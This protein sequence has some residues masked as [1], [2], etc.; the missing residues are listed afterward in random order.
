MKA[1]TAARLVNLAVALVVLIVTVV[2]ICQSIVEKDLRMPEIGTQACYDLEYMDEDT[3][4]NNIVNAI[5]DLSG[6]SVSFGDSTLAVDRDN[7]REVASAIYSSG[8]KTAT[9]IGP[10]GGTL[11]QQSIDYRTM[12]L[13]GTKTG[14]QISGMAETVSKMETRM[15]ILSNDGRID[16]ISGI[17][18]TTDGDGEVGAACIIPL[19][20][21]NVAGAYGCHMGVK[22][23]VEY[24]R[25]AE[26]TV[27]SGSY[28][29][30]LP[31]S[32][33][34]IDSI[35]G[36]T[37]MTVSQCDVTGP[38]IG[39][40]GDVDMKFEVIG[41]NT[42]TL[43]CTGKLSDALRNSAEDGCLLITMGDESYLMDSTLTS[44]FISAIKTMEAAA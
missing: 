38:G 33:Y 2:P 10:D 41:G 22:I 36:M 9:V 5:G 21:Y 42:M 27:D 30:F 44:S 28:D 20:V 34:T 31:D 19:A 11:V 1:G 32:S 14:V 23:S 37:V 6:C 35:D 7:V 29:N 3:L 8:T 39:K 4:G 24:E 43:S 40:I 25:L 12:L 26:V 16:I 18:K 15:H 17:H 13:I